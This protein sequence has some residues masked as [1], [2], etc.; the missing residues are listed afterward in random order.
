MTLDNNVENSSGGMQAW[1]SVI[2]LL[3]DSASQLD[4]RITDNVG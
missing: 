1:N 2:A 4:L 3:F